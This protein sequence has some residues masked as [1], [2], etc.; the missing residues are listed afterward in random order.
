MLV[1][2][3]ARTTVPKPERL[4]LDIGNSGGDVQPGLALHT[5]GLQRVGILRTADQKIAAAADPDRSVGADAAVIAG[6]IAASNPPARRIHRPAQFGL[7]GDAEI[8]NK[9]MHGCDVWFGTATLALE[10]AFEAGHRA[11]DKTDIL[12]ALALQD[13]GAELRLRQCVGARE[14]CR[15]RSDG[16][17]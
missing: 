16:D 1:P 17:A 14:R 9:A 8:Q 4:Q 12:A 15:E 5:N 3:P 2:K 13:A 6:K 11:N 10:H 7:V